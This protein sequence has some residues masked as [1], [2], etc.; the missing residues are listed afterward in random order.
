VSRLVDSWDSSTP[1]A[2]IAAPNESGSPELTVNCSY[3]KS[4]VSLISRPSRPEIVVCSETCA[5]APESS[6][7]SEDPNFPVS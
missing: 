1:S 6:T 5:G 4:Q 2:S 7:A 3:S